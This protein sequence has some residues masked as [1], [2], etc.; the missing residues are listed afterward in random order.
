MKKLNKTQLKKW[1]A[2][3]V[4]FEELGETLTDRLVQMDQVIHDA[5]Q[6]FQET[7]SDEWGK[8]LAHLDEDDDVDLSVID[9]IEEFVSQ[10]HGKLE[11][12]YDAKSEKWQESD[13][14]QALCEAKDEWEELSGV[15]L[16]EGFEDEPDL[17]DPEVLP[18]L[19]EALPTDYDDLANLPVDW[20]E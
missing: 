16:W 4:R 17:D 8:L 18:E 5:R 15:A 11:D 14:G 2:L 13:R 10:V 1:T 3:L 12:V 19:S 7:I 9:E 6:T 20:S